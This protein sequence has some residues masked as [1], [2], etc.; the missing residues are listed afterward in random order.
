MRFILI[1]IVF[2]LSIFS[3]KK[4]TGNFTIKGTITD[5]SFSKGLDG[6][7]ATLYQV[8]SD[9]NKKLV[10][11]VALA[12]DGSYS[13]VFKREKM[14]KYILSVTKDNYFDIEEVI[15][16]SN[17][18]LSE[19]NVKNYSTTAKSWVRLKFFNNTP[20][21]YDQLDYTKQQ[22]KSPC[23]TCSPTTEQT[24]IGAIDTSFVYINDGNTT[25]SYIYSVFGTTN[26][27]IKSVVTVPFD[28]TEIYLSY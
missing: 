3:C 7:T 24:L 2:S 11:S 10:S 6:A 9:N 27:G 20:S 4:G 23:S 1:T 18:S 5:D 21:V 16:F 17:L 14:D 15:P 26:Q 25:F 19:D 13:F 8:T 28:T 22:G 12:S